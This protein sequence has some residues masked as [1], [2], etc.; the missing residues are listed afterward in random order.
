MNIN[1]HSNPTEP[2][3]VYGPKPCRYMNSAGLR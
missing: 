3:N 1:T 2:L